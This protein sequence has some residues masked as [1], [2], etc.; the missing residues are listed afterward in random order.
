MNIELQKREEKVQIAC[1][2]FHE[3]K[4]EMKIPNSN[5]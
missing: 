1:N 4:K 3:D 5:W 2:N